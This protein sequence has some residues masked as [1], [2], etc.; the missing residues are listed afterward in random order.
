MKLQYLPQKMD[1]WFE[2]CLKTKGTAYFLNKHQMPEDLT[3]ALLFFTL[4][5]RCD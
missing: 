4:N 1:E 2:F 5:S 3:M